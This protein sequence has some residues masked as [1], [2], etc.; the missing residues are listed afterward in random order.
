MANPLH[1]LPSEVQ[2]PRSAISGYY[3]HNKNRAYDPSL[4]APNLNLKI[5][6]LVFAYCNPQET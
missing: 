1:M 3:M 4:L 6:I 5:Y 2:M